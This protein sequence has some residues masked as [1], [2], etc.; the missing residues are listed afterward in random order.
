MTHFDLNRMEAYLYIA[1]LSAFGFGLY[2]VAR[3]FWGFRTIY[4]SMQ[5]GKKRRWKGHTHLEEFEKRV[6]FA[7]FFPGI[8]FS[9][10]LSGMAGIFLL[11]FLVLIV[12]TT[13]E[14]YTFLW[15]LR[16]MLVWHG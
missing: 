2:I 5:S 6:D 8:V 15:I 3:P 10:V 7:T 16:K 4:E 9:T 12:L 11:V 1:A 14:F 13:P